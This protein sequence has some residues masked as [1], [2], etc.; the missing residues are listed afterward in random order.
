[1]AAEWLEKRKMMCAVVPMERRRTMRRTAVAFLFLFLLLG[2]PNQAVAATN[3]SF[4]A[5]S[6]GGLLEDDIDL[7]Q[8]P[9]RI[10]EIDGKRIWTNLS[11]FV[12]KQE[13]VFGGSSNNI[14]LVGGA[15]SWG[16]LHG[17]LVYDRSTSRTALGTGLSTR[18]QGGMASE[19]L[20]IGELDDAQFADLNGDNAFDMLTLTH[21]RRERF[22]DS[23]YGTILAVVAKELG[24]A[25]IG[26]RA[27]RYHSKRED[28][29][30]QYGNS[31]YN[32]ERVKTATDLI[33]GLPVYS[34]DERG[35]QKR[36]RESTID[37]ILVSYWRPIRAGLEGGA[38]FGIDRI[39]ADNN[40]S[41]QETHITNLT[42]AIPNANTHNSTL[43]EEVVRPSEGLN[44][45]GGV[46][47][48]YEWSPEIQYRVFVDLSRETS[49]LDSEAR[50]LEIHTGTDRVTVGSDVQQDSYRDSTSAPRT[51]D[52]SRLTGSFF[53][54]GVR[55]L[56]DDATFA[57]GLRLTT[58][59][60]EA[61]G[62]TKS[63]TRDVYR[64][65]DGDGVQTDGDYIETTTGS[66][67]LVNKTTSSLREISIPV[68]L[69]FRLRKPVML[70]LGA[71]HYES[72]M[73]A[74]VTDH[75]KAF[76]AEVTRTEYGDGS[77]EEDLSSGGSQIPGTT[78]TRK[79]RTSDTWY[80]YG[81]GIQATENLQIDVMGFSDVTDLS[82]WKLSAVVKLR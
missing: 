4:R 16:T 9:A 77:V 14:L 17:A 73:E 34:D 27:S 47:G 11:N 62:E 3:D 7:L 31:G 44:L 55:K 24:D 63:Q 60:Y 82:Q 37:G 78:E 57:M 69:E 30:D 46:T 76:S 26:V 36:T 29:R 58:S 52:D 70:R 75:Q 39:T 65:D 67:T 79:T 43:N 23:T 49:E 1:V 54:Y 81:L 42:P 41:R 35:T 22:D 38:R 48:F 21:E 33:T 5:A 61:T 45:H 32:F 2:V 10:T 8:D 66:Q 40:H 6:T 50:N 56:S 20:G 19:M 18:P 12:N 28:Q 64:V 25:R 71:V 74:T 72:F 13:E 51:G 53:G 15:R 68:G 59:S 80:S